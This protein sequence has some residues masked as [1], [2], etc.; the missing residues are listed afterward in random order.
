MKENKSWLSKTIIAGIAVII[1]GACSLGGGD[2]GGGGGGI[3]APIKVT[4]KGTSQ[5]TITLA[6]TGVSGAA[7]Y[8]IYYSVTSTG[9]FRY[10]DETEENSY[11]VSSLVSNKTYFYKVSAVDIDGMESSLSLYASGST[12]ND[13]DEEVVPDEPDEPGK[14]PDDGKP[15]DGN[16]DNAVPVPGSV[17][18]MVISGS[19]IRI[20]W[21]AVSGAAS[22]KVYRSSSASGTYSLLGTVSASPYNDN[23]LSSGT[24]YYYKVSAVKGSEESAQSNY[25]SAGTGGTIINPP[26]KPT[27]LVASI[28][29]NGS[30]TLSWDSVSTADSYNVYRANTQTGAS[31][32]IT[33]VTGTGY[34]DN[35]S[36][37]ISYFYTVTGVNSSGES[38]KSAAAFGF[39]SSHYS[40]SLYSEAQIFSLAA[41][42]KHYYRLPVNAGDSHTIQWQNGSDAELSNYNS[43]S[44]WQNDGT[45]IFT[46]ASNGYSSPQVFTATTTGFVTVE[47]KNNHGSASYNYQVYYF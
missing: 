29:A 6:W 25:V 24:T 47:V 37:G 45:V 12:W 16:N 5:T 14:D 8:N 35:V 19:S 20:S 36:A 7:K 41:G 22:Y 15:D 3:A 10:L 31:G 1:L 44:A 42:V 21:S 33:T 18:A 28:V 32:K 26:T 17:N 34:S 4:A 38:P 43:V 23:G 11:V 13:K 9:V 39:A 27:G 46:N 30:I 2:G 40:L